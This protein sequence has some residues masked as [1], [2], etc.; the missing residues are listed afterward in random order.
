M[1]FPSRFSDF[2]DR[3]DLA[4][5]HIRMLDIR[6]Q[7]LA[8]NDNTPLRA[9][10]ILGKGAFGEIPSVT[11]SRAPIDAPGVQSVR[12]LFAFQIDRLADEIQRSLDGQVWRG[13]FRPDNRVLAR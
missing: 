12:G 2:L 3:P 8:H 4:D 11:E 6:N 5:L 10:V 13:P 9:T 7:A 1:Q